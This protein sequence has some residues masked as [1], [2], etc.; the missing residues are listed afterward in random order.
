LELLSRRRY[1]AGDVIEKSVELVGAPGVH[2]FGTH[3]TGFS[4]KEFS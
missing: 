4:N 3:D 1:E 2:A